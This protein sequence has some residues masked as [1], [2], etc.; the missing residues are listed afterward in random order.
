MRKQSKVIE[1]NYGSCITHFYINFLT[2]SSH[3]VHHKKKWLEYTNEPVSKRKTT[4][5]DESKLMSDIEKAE[6]NWIAMKSQ[7]ISRFIALYTYRTH[8]DSPRTWILVGDN[9]LRLQR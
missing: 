9:L 1:Y 6:P 8:L 5:T 2:F 7:S 3:A 4:N